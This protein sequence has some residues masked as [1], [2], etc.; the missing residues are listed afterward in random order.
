MGT[1][2]GRA[3]AAALKMLE[4]LN[5]INHIPEFIKRA[6]DKN[7]S[8]CL[9]EFG[10]RVYKNHYLRDTV[11]AETCYQVLK[12]L[13]KKDNNLLQVAMELEYITLN[14][15]YVIKKK[16]YPN[17]DFYSGIMLK[18]MVIPSSMF[19]VIFTIAQYH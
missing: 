15:L 17:I 13:H 19:T 5:F 2:H 16:L 4:E 8:F 9:M 10:Y 7:N 3:N 14:N 1:A 6:K 18:A 12:V 11:M